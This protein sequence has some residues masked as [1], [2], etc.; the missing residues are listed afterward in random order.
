MARSLNTRCDFKQ[1][2][3]TCDLLV[4]V[5]ELTLHVKTKHGKHMLKEDQEK[6][7]EKILALGEMDGQ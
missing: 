1:A 7:M 2:F 4:D 3:V 6:R 5:V